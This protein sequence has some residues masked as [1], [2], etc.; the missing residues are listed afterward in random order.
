MRALTKHPRPRLLQRVTVYCGGVN[1]TCH[2]PIQPE[3]LFTQPEP[4]SP[5]GTTAC[6][7]LAA[8][9]VYASLMPT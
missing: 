4:P 8:V 5:D 3:T 1:G 2:P 7:G 9:S 6:C